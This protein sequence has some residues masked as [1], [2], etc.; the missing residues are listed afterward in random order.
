MGAVCGLED[1]SGLES[2]RSEIGAV[3]DRSGL[4]SER[5]GAVWDPEFGPEKVRKIDA[6]RATSK[7][8]FA[9]LCRQVKV[10]DDGVGGVDF[11]GP[12]PQ[13]RVLESLP[14]FVFGL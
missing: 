2:E 7:S 8:I 12:S 13:R 9:Q 3:W 14:S 4:G 5:S 1:R 11:S 10:S 6:L